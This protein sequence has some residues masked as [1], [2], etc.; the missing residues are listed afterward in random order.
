MTISVPTVAAVLEQAAIDCGYYRWLLHD[1]SMVELRI[2][3][4]LP[5]LEAAYDPNDPNWMAFVDIGD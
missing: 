1:G 4:L 5:A 3:E 2:D